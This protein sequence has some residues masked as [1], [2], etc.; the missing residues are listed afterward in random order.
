MCKLSIV[1]ELSSR[2]QILLAHV[3]PRNWA[4]W[5]QP[6]A[7]FDNLQMAISF[8]IAS[9]P[10]PFETIIPGRW[11]PCTACKSICWGLMWLLLSLFRRYIRLFNGDPHPVKPQPAAIKL[12]TDR[13]SHHPPPHISFYISTYVH[14]RRFV[15]VCVHL[16]ARFRTLN[17]APFRKSIRPSVR[18]ARTSIHSYPGD[19]G[20]WG[21]IGYWLLTEKLM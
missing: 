18:R 17:R 4:N 16:T 15:R 12:T 20:V 10:L 6:Q 1:T 7:K 21:L 3:H 9:V 11:Q 13:L 2:W 5:G 19:C 14:I 8:L